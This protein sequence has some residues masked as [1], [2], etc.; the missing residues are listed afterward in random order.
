VQCE[1]ANTIILIL[2]I[3]Q[4]IDYKKKN[5]YIYISIIYVENVLNTQANINIFIN[6]FNI[7]NHLAKHL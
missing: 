4:F 6:F 7:I 2:I 1:Q 3:V 5:I